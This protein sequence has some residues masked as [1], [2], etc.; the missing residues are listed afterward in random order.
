MID[1]ILKT[2]DEIPEPAVILTEEE[3]K[4][5]LELFY[6]VEG[7]LRI[8]SGNTGISGIL[9]TLGTELDTVRH[10]IER[11]KELRGRLKT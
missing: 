4:I 7:I 1:E 8:N 3:R 6:D 2:W 5:L 10:N 9:I 11:L